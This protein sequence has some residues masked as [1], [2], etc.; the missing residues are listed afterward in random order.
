MVPAPAADPTTFRISIGNDQ[1]AKPYSASIFN[2]SAMSFGS[3]SANAIRSLNK[4]AR[5]GNFAHD[6]GEG[7]Y[8]PYHRENGGDIIWEIGSGYFS[9]RNDD[10][11]FCPE[12]FAKN[13]ANDQVKM[14]ELKLS[15]GAKPG[16]G[17]VL[18]AAKVS[19][20]IAET[21]GVPEGKDCNSPARHSAFSTPIE[22]M[23]FI[24]TM[25]RL[26][27]GKPTGFKL[28][29]GHPWEFL[30]VCKAMLETEIY[31]DFIVVDGKEGGTGAAPLEFTDHLGMPLREGLNFVHNALIGINARDR[32]KLGASGKIVSAFDIARVMALG[33]DWCNSARGFMFALG[34]IQSQSC[35][36]DMCPTGVATQDQA[37]Q[38]AL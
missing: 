17:G 34:C 37:R 16:H 22:L 8:S 28:C 19:P 3:L 6:T 18:P 7:G 31:P 21:R 11:T 12:K 9:C 38:R 26:S 36:T 13:A 5:K 33:A 29:I 30:A 15:Q 27:G 23:Q 35:H 1:C 20:E 32:I 25:R 2:V 10:G 24:A 14:V 4:G